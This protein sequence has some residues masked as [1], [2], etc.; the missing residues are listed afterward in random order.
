MSYA[1]LMDK[2]NREYEL[3][4]E[5]ELKKTPAEVFQDAFKIVSIEQTLWMFE[6][7]L[8]DFE[9]S[10][11]NLY[12]KLL[13]TEDVLEYIYIETLGYETP[14]V[15]KDDFAYMLEDLFY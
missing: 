8:Q 6:Y 9:S 13:Q 7:Y 10:L 11:P 4:K 5:I 3:F 15:D 14:I 12:E 1:K 2:V